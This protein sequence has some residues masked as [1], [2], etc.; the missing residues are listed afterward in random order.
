M[1]ATEHRPDPWNTYVA[2]SPIALAEQESIRARFLRKT[3]GHL[4]G[5][6]ALF[7]AIEALIFAVMP[8]PSLARMTVWM[9]SGWHWLLVLGAFMVVSMIAESMAFSATNL[10]AQYAG[11]VLYVAA[12]AVI[13]VPLLYVAHVLD[14]RAGGSH[15]ILKAAVITLVAF[16]GLTSVVMVTKA[17]FG[18]LRTALIVASFV[19]MGVVLAGIFFGGF[20]IGLFGI[21]AFI[22]L[23]IGWILYSTSEVLHRAQE[24]QYVAAAIALFA[25]LALLFWYVLQLV[26]A[27]SDND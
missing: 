4:A 10:A 15:L 17:D 18:W 9:M 25:S 2:H 13:F 27:L 21:G 12:E 19:A 23:A 6:V 8:E 3:Y 14:Q 11:L 5:A 20:S 26:I 1:A 24:D 22:A 16:G 7:A